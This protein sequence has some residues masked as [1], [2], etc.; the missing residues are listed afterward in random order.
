MSLLSVGP[1]IF[2]YPRMSEPGG[3][4]VTGAAGSELMSNMAPQ[5]VEA[6]ADPDQ[7]EDGR[8]PA[9]HG[10]FSSR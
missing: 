4:S 6:K 8:N 2:Q 9:E 7:Y 1:A 10:A 3:A 5:P